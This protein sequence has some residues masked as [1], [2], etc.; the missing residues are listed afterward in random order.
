MLGARATDVTRAHLDAPSHLGMSAFAI[1]EKLAIDQRRPEL[2]RLTDP[3]HQKLVQ[4]SCALDVDN[5]STRCESP[6]FR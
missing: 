6:V 5:W 2:E 4:V 1:A 3:H